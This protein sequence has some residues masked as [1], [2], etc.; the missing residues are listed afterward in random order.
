MAN[1]SQPYSDAAGVMDVVLSRITGLNE[2]NRKLVI[3]WTIATHAL[4]YLDT[5]PMLVLLGKMGTGKSQTLKVVEHFAHK[6][7]AF[8][9][10]ARTLPVIRDEL[11]KCDGGTAVIE[12]ADQAWK[13]L[14]LFERLLSDRYQRA[15]AEAALKEPVGSRG[16]ETS[17]MKYFGATA[18]HRRL[19]FGDAALNGRSVLVHFRPNHTRKYDDYSQHQ[20]WLR[21]QAALIRDMP[22]RLPEVAP[23]EGVAA[24]TF[25]TYRP[26]LATALMYNDLAFPDQIRAQLLLETAELKEAQS[27]EPDGLVLRAIIEAIS[28]ESGQFVFTKHVRI[29]ALTR[30]IFENH[31]VG[32]LPQQV[33]AIARQLGFTTKNSHGVRVVVPKPIPLIRA[34]RECGYQDEAIEK[35]A[36]QMLEE[37]EDLNGG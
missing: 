7:H 32:M 31:H 27:I 4:P 28:S 13:D 35:L 8:S 19:P 12:E 17:T 25:Q 18:M 2:V 1:Q 23:P 26:L 37:G 14:E 10:R 21:R 33:G 34:C 3:Y 20:D 11:A 6:A 36:K 29:S 16:W 24:R 9:L 15:S 30:S 22:L 5:F